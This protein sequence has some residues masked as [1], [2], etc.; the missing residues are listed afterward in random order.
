MT[1][2][3]KRIRAGRYTL[4]QNGY[5]FDLVDNQEG[6]WILSNHAGVELYRDST[7]QAVVNMLAS[8]GT[9]GCRELHRQAFCT[10]A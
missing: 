8:Y 10:Y 1:P 2:I 5:R 3:V 4:N 7:K 9:D 6:S